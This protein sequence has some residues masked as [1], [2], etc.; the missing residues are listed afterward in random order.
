MYC[1][2]QVSYPLERVILQTQRLSV[3]IDRCHS[4]ISPPTQQTCKHNRQSI[5]EGL[6][7]SPTN[8]WLSLHFIKYNCCHVFDVSLQ[9]LMNVQLSRLQ[10]DLFHE[11]KKVLSMSFM[12]DKYCKLVV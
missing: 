12:H 7:F 1:A 4:L 9:N 8:S 10:Q 3:Y 2:L 5:H 6:L 11:L